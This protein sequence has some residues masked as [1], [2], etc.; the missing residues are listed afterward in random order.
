MC[1]PKVIRGEFDSSQGVLLMASGMYS[2]SNKFFHQKA[3]LAKTVNCYTY[4]AVGIRSG[5]PIC[6]PDM[7]L[8]F[9]VTKIIYNIQNLGYRPI[10]Y[11]VGSLYDVVSNL[12][13]KQTQLEFK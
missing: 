9:Q 13:H 5:T 8:W 1:Q 12:K 11:V 4:I 7:F 3:H 6:Q 10:S 2:P